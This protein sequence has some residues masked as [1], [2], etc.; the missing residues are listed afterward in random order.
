ML[1]H[2]F[3]EA[4]TVSR[5]RAS[6]A[7]ALVAAAVAIPARAGEPPTRA[8]VVAVVKARLPDVS[9]CYQRALARKPWLAGRVDVS[10]SVDGEGRVARVEIERT[11]LADVRFLACA[12]DAIRAWTF[13]HA[14]ASTPET[15]A[16]TLDV[17]YPFVFGGGG[18]ARDPSVL[19]DGRPRPVTLPARCKL[20]AECR[21]LGASL[22]SGSDADQARAFAFFS[23]GCA[24]KDGACCA[25]AAAARDGG[26][27][28]AKDRKKAFALAARACALGHE[29]ACTT[30]AMSH[31]LGVEAAGVR[32]DPVK[33]TALLERACAANEGTACLNLAERLRLGLGV[34][35]NEARAADLRARALAR[36]D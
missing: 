18:G 23:T 16:G 13:P 12:Q 24:L 10:F 11:E 8:S 5:P 3:P 36:A 21:E 9:A 4:G 27:G 33:A 6:I 17:T 20:P 19:V 35:R 2:G 14:A 32:K 7:T 31:A 30:V 26:R 1:A 22:A 25:G 28:V 29:R 34:A 15:A